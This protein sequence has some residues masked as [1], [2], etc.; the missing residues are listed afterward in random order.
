[1]SKLICNFYDQ[2]ADILFNVDSTIECAIT[3]IGPRLELGTE[4]RVAHFSTMIVRHG[5]GNLNTLKGS[6]LK[7]LI[8][9]KS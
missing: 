5:R 8:G 9:C 1:M 4:I 6:P 3:E 2:G 7:K